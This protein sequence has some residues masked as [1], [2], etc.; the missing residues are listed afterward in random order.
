MA[1]RA[2]CSRTFGGICTVV[3][4]SQWRTLLA[5]CCDTGCAALPTTICSMALATCPLSA[6]ERS[7]FTTKMTAGCVLALLGF[8]WYSQTK[9]AEATREQ[10]RREAPRSE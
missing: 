2:V 3:A 10:Q 8:G 5:A 7:E 4:A 6:G 9:L 1:W